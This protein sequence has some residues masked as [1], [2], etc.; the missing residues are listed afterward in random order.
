MNGFKWAGVF[1]SDHTSLKG[2]SLKGRPISANNILK[3]TC[4][5]K[6]HSNDNFSA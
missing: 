6:T 3:D 5:T 2:N 4:R 1:R